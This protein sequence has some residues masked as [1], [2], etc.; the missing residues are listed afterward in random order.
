M[1]TRN[2]SGFTLIE[3]LI[4]T[5]IMFTSITI[6]TIGYRGAFISSEKSNQQIKLNRVVTLIIDEVRQKIRNINFDDVTLNGSGEVFEIKYSWTAELI[7]HEAAPKKLNVDSGGYITPPLKY[8]LWDVTLDV[9]FLSLKK[10]YKYQELSW[11][12][13]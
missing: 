1:C 3:I 12:D 9:N 8:K 4:A 6:V 7:K 11:S 5:V 13:A 10:I 2:Q